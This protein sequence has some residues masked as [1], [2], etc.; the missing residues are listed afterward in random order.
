MYVLI[1]V[2]CGCIRKLLPDS[3]RGKKG[4]ELQSA[5]SI[6]KRESGVTRFDEREYVH[7]ARHIGGGRSYEVVLAMARKALERM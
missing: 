7:Y 6:D 1:K 5:C 4:E 3:W 2:V